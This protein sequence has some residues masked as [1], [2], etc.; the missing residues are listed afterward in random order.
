MSAPQRAASPF[1]RVA[2]V[3][4]GLMGGSVA[5]AAQQM[6]GVEE[7]VV[8]DVDPET[9]AE[10]ARLGVGHRQ[11]PD[12]AS[13][14]AGA[15]LVVLATPVTVTVRVHASLQGLLA[16]DTVVTDVSSTKARVLE[17]IEVG[18]ATDPQGPHFIGGHPMAGSERSGVAA[19]DAT[20]FQG[21]TWVLT[22]TARSEASAFEA[23]SSFLRALGARVLAVDPALHDRLV[24]IASHLP[25][26]LA[27]T[28][29]DEA[30]EA[31]ERTG[32]A[33]LA[34]AAGGFRDATRVAGS[35]PGLWVGILRENRTAVLEAIDGF[36]AR[37]QTVRSAVAEQDWVQLEAVLDRARAARERLPSK[38]RAGRLYD[39]VIPVADR[40]AVLAAVT[41]ALG[42]AGVNIEDLAMRH[43]S[44][45]ERGALL[46]AVDG[47][48][49]ARRA[50]R[51]L[52]ER[53]LPSHVE[54]R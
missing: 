20:L 37:L 18:D 17:E 33:V 50:R 9:L 27:S 53:G 49:A 24:A 47:E 32:E 43:A 4:C 14:V 30:A 40:P 41:T 39:L 29:M 1:A 52:A 42:E 15:Q 46:V 10:A 3:G 26:V 7:V 36:L 51:L 34:V 22:P 8:T 21:A 11:E 28:L 19:A 2:V 5:L 25:Q 35:D 16:P 54:P 38:Q 31:A 6:A 13:A 12:L 44:D 45:L 48:A 23:L